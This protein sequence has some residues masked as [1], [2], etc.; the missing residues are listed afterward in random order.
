MSENKREETEAEKKHREERAERHG[1]GTY[2][3]EEGNSASAEDIERAK[4]AA[5]L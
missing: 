5:G 4:K 3:V 1:A 2:R